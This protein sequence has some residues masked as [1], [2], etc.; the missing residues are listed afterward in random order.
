M[1]TSAH[2]VLV[3]R[4]T[5][6]AVTVQM[7]LPKPWVRKIERHPKTVEAVNRSDNFEI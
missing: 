2:P 5:A 7:T 1:A 6:L 3:S 4:R